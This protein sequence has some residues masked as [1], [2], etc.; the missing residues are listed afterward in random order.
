M[1]INEDQ[2]GKNP[3]ASG[4]RIFEEHNNNINNSGGVTSI[5]LN[6]GRTRQSNKSMSPSQHS[7]SYYPKNAEEFGAMVSDVK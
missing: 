2:I 5:A 4:I 6:G 7:G 1:M 3:P